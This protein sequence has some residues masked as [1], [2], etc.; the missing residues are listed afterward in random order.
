MNQHKNDSINETCSNKYKTPLALAIQKYGWENF[1]LTILEEHSDPNIIN[2]LEIKYIKEFNTYGEN[3]YNASIGGEFGYSGRKYISKIEKDFD[4]IVYD[5][6][7]NDKSI[8]ELS[9]KYNISESYLSDINT[10]A[11]LYKDYLSY[12]LRP[13]PRSYLIADYPKIIHDL[14]FTNI[15]M[16]QLAKKYHTSLSTIQ[17]INKGNKTAKM[18]YDNFPIR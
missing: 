4:E 15:S 8:R 16:R 17:S 3:G 14:R 10:G 5:L 12:P 11:R 9:Q 13:Q 1:E 2:Q 18:F 7:F 6:K